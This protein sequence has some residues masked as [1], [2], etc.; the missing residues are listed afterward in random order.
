MRCGPLNARMPQRQCLARKPSETYIQPVPTHFE[1]RRRMSGLLSILAFV[2]MAAVAVVLVFGLFNMMR[3]GS[4]NTSQKLMRLRI[5]LQ[6]IA[7]V[8][9]V[10]AILLSR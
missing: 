7:I 6:G 1:S 8:V 3:G 10:G 2:L 9:I 5:L 4:G